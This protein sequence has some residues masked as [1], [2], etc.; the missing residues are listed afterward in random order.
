MA[1]RLALDAAVE[2]AGIA[3]IDV[4]VAFLMLGGFGFIGALVVGLPL[5]LRGVSVRR[6]ALLAFPA[7]LLY[8]GYWAYWTHQGC[9]HSCL[10]DPTSIIFVSPMQLG[11][12]AVGVYVGIVVAWLT[13]RTLR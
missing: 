10:R 3:M 8:N 12:W 11:G 4:L 5:I 7:F 1:N 13:G 2:L 9:G 6:V